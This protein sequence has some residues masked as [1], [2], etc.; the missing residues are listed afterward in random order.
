M[1]ASD[2][3]TSEDSVPH[4]AGEALRHA[5]EDNL[6]SLWHREIVLEPAEKT[7]LSGREHVHRF[8]VRNA[9][10]TAPASVIVKQARDS[11]EHLRMFHNE[12]ASLALLSE[13]CP[14]PP[15]PRLYHG[16][17]ERHFLLMEDLGSGDRLDHALR[18]NDPSRATQMLVSLCE[19]LGKMHSATFGAGHRLDAI[20]AEHGAQRPERD[21]RWPQQRAAMDDALNR[22][23]LR[24]HDQ[25]LEEMAG[26]QHHT[27]SADFAVLLHGDPCPD[28]CQR[29]GGRVKLLDFEHGRFGNA[30]NDGCYPLVH[31]PTCWCMGRLPDDV[32]GKALSAYRA[33]LA[34]GVPAA[35]DEEQFERGML[36]ASLLWAWGTFAGWHMPKVL[37][38]DD[39]W[40]LATVRQRILF[41][42][43]LLL[44]MLEQN[45][46]YPGIEDTTRRT[47]ENVSGRWT[48]VADMPDYPAFR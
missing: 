22:L 6:A 10:D 33:A 19:T 11:D 12:W 28:N 1:L 32:T 21:D 3:D 47:L 36:D 44:P 31:F 48:D 8:R 15:A 27:E 20:L 38:R 40:G 18:G 46:R 2:V 5:A 4:L 30:F 41:R 7:G 24:P 23:G 34:G 14:D 26:I 35:S 29:V 9:G 17:A 13:L 43:R 16:D 45:G 25:F 37:E 39:E 42:F